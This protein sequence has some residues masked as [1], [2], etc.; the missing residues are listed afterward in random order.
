M[1]NYSDVQQMLGRAGSIQKGCFAWGR[2]KHGGRLFPTVKLVKAN[3]E[4]VMRKS[5][6]RLNFVRNIVSHFPG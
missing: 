2:L 1:L 5:L 4:Y 3:D 6:V